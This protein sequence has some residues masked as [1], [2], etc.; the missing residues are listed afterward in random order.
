[1]KDGSAEEGICSSEV[2]DA[3]L[4]WGIGKVFYCESVLPNLDPYHIGCCMLARCPPHFSPLRNH[5][6]RT[7]LSQSPARPR[8]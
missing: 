1:M 5:G 8:H 7:W 2:G 6:Q 4:V 3:L